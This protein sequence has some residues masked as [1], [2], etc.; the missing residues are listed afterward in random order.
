MKIVTKKEFLEKKEFFIGEMKKGKI[1]VY[2]TDTIYGIGCDAENKESVNRIRE[3]KNREKKPFSVV[4]PNKE[5]ILNNCIVDNNVEKWLDKLPG[6]YTLIL[7]L[8]ERGTIGVRIPNNWF[9]KIVEKF[10]KPFVTTSVNLFGEQ[11]IKELKDLK[12]E[13]KEKIDYF[14]DIG[15]IDGRASKI[16][17]LIGEEEI[18]ER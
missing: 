13:I 8:K 9:S 1:F 4:V 5:W 3:I 7:N 18:L 16:V 10:G 11:P 12:E 6:K 15:I 17:K 14:I 2:P